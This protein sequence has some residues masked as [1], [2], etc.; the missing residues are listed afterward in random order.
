VFGTPRTFE[1][2]L[3]IMGSASTVIDIDET[4]Y[5]VRI[6]RDRIVGV[7]RVLKYQSSDCSGTPYFSKSRTELTMADPVNI[8]APSNINT[9]PDDMALFVPDTTDVNLTFNSFYDA[10]FNTC[11]N[12]PNN[13][14]DGLEAIPVADLDT[15]Y[16]P[17]FRI[18]GAKFAPGFKIK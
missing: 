18:K 6:R 4:F 12:F 16:T 10:R 13:V 11:V 9:D 1:N 2:T 14:D 5:P 17:P 15:M 8:V 7:L 3:N